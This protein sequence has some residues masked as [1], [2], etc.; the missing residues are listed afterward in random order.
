MKAHLWSHP[1]QNR[2]WPLTPELLNIN[3][4]GCIPHP[5][6][7]HYCRVK[8]AESTLQPSPLSSLQV[9]SSLVHYLVCH[10][11]WCLSVNTDFTEKWCSLQTSWGFCV[12]SC[13]MVALCQVPS[14]LM[15]FLL[16]N[17]I[18]ALGPVW[19]SHSLCGRKGGLL[20]LCTIL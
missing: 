13:P 7:R 1:S 16:L 11:W 4:E 17:T 12:F 5:R 3:W 10:R 2:K 15:C 20:V 14:L 9:C 6:T 19:T 18:K 8:E